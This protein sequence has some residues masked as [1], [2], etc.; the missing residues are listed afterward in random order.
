MIYTIFIKGMKIG[1]GPKYSFDYILKKTFIFTFGIP[2]GSPITKLVPLLIGFIL[3]M[4]LVLMVRKRDSWWIWLIVTSVISP[5]LVHWLR[6]STF[7]FVRYFLVCELFF[8]FIWA[9]ILVW[10]WNH[11]SWALKELFII[12]W[13][14]FILAQ[15]PRLEALIR[16]GRGQYKKALKFIINETNNYY[17]QDHYY[18]TVGSDHNF[19]N[20][21][22]VEYFKR[23]IEGG[24]RIKYIKIRKKIPMFYLK[25]KFGYPVMAKRLWIRKQLFEKKKSFL[26][27]NGLSGWS[28][29]VYVRK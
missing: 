28:W 25:H 20:R 10:L 29:Y 9:E 19:R 14:G 23:R 24:H 6:P 22:V 27:D 5:L 2:V 8:L 26:Y 7:L 12:L 3:I 13:L 4:G 1:G 16:H 15:V 11:R 21:T 18:I 17:D